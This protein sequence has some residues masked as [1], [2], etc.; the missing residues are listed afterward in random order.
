VCWIVHIWKAEPASQGKSSHICS[1]VVIVV[2]VVELRFE[3][4][5][6]VYSSTSKLPDDHTLL[7]L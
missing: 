7:G 6:P 4:S 3:S 5:L 2:V 1:N